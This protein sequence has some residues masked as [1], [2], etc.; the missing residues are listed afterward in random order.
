MEK[1]A[2]VGG[3][4]CPVE[5]HE[6]AA[7]FCILIVLVIVLLFLFE[8]PWRHR[9]DDSRPGVRRGCSV[10][11]AWSLGNL[12]IVREHPRINKVNRA[13]LNSGV[14]LVATF[15]QRQPICPVILAGYYG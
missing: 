3:P 4:M 10:F 6:C 11:I 2:G 7:F 9:D 1:E 13:A 5:A 12:F 14:C 15:I 8:K